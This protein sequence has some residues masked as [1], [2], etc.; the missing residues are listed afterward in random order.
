M[1]VATH[2]RCSWHVPVVGLAATGIAWLFGVDLV[3]ALVMGIGT[4]VVVVL[5]R[6]V[7][8]VPDPGW[9]RETPPER[10]GARGDLAT[11][12]WTMVGRDGRAGERALR[13]VRAVAAGRLA[14][15][16]LDLA[17]PAD[18]DAI[19]ALLGARAWAVL[20][21][22]HGRPPSIADVTHTVERLERLDPAAPTLAPAAHRSPRRTT[23]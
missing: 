4:A 11:L 22:V 6:T 7:D 23:R 12:S 3:H 20:G 1:S 21:T 16:G 9:E 19:R 14:R 13:R 18:A 10:H 2:L 15:S 8:L 17:D 5:A